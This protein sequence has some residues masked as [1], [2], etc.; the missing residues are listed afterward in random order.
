MPDQGYFSDP[1]IHNDIV[2][3]VCEDDL[4]T[5]PAGGGL[6]RRLTASPAQEA[7]PALSPDG[8]WLAFTSRDEGAPEIYAM[9][10]EGGPARRL[11]YLGAD[12][13]VVGWH[14][15]GD[16]IIFA[17]NTAQPIERIYALH[18]VKPSGGLPVLLP[19]GPAVSIS[20]GSV[21][22]NFGA[23]SGMAAAGVSSSGSFSERDSMPA[24]VSVSARGCVIG[25]H[26][27]DLAR[28]KRYRGGLAGALWIDPAGT[29]DW[30][31]LIELSGN[32]AAP[33]W[34]GER[35]YFLSDHEGV[36]NLY[37]C[38][39]D[40]GDLRR[41]TRHN[42]FYVR[43]PSTDGR[44]IVYQAGAD[45]YL[46][47]PVADTS[48]VIPIALHSPRAQRARR[49]VDAAHYLQGYAL[50]PAG[51]SL[52]LVARGKPFTM[53]N[54]EG[55]VVQH[56]LAQG[57]R[58]RLAAWLPDG[59]RLA[60]I[61]DAAGEETVE[62]HHADGSAEPDR[63]IGLD[64][65]RPEEVAVS[66]VADQLALSNQRYELILVDLAERS[67]RVLDRSRFDPLEGLA[68]SPDGKWLA[69]GL[70]VGQ[71][72]SII[73]LCRVETGQ[74]WDVTRPV[75]RDVSPAFDP[76]GDYLY[77]LSFRDF[78]PV[79]DNLHFDL[80]FPRG[81][82]P[83]LVTLRADLRS[84]FV[85]VPRPFKKPEVEREDDESDAAS[86]AGGP[87]TVPEDESETEPEVPP[88]TIDLDGLP[89][90]V[91]AFPVPAGRYGQVWGLPGKVLFSRFPIESAF[92]ESGVDAGEP[93]AR[94]KLAV[95]SFEDRE[96][97]E[98]V[99]GITD[100]EV[101]LDGS[102]LLY[103]AGDRLRVIEAGKKPPED[104]DDGDRPG[105]KS[106]WLDLGRVRVGVEPPGEWAQMYREA[107]RLQRDQFWTADMSGVDWQAIYERYRPLLDRVA[108][109]SE[110][111]DLLW[112]MQGELG[113]SHAYEFGGDYRPGPEY[114]QGFLGVDIAYDPADDGYRLA[115]IVAGDVW[116]DRAS[117]PL[118]RPG[119][120]AQP[121]D[122]ILA[123]NGQAV[124]GGV[125]PQEL[126]VNQAHNE[127]LLTLD[128]AAGRRSLA[129]P[130][131]RSEVPARYR[132]WVESNRRQVH[133]ATGGRVGYVHIP[134]MGE[135]GYAEFHRGYLLEVE[136]EGLIVD[137]RYNAGG[138][139]SQLILEKLARRRLGFDIRRWGEPIPY[140][141]ESV[142]GPLVALANE[143]SGSDGDMFAHA[144]KLMS[145]GPL[146]GKRTWGG[147]VG[148]EFRDTLVDNGI[149]TQ[150]EYAT[151]F[152]D[153]AYGLEN[154][155]TD[156]DIGVE[157]R[158]Q[159][160]VAGRDPQLERA[161]G[162][163]VRLLA[164]HPP[165]VP[166][167]LRMLP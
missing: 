61:S 23:E 139:V 2:V 112:E 46:Y 158:P 109:R 18:A 110:F 10:A 36:A 40:G 14:P 123:I 138:Y 163:A 113:T 62:I 1:T 63:L 65:G 115:R 132:D 121:G 111:S 156:P 166:G 87:S 80:N 45:L 24:L 88:I 72:T 125:A 146:I 100:F 83:Y 33:L 41:H 13:W 71:Q 92:D 39:I 17:S 154:Y 94:G 131:L 101:S 57:A 144:F 129:V 73:K 77:F 104:D 122:R 66:P 107:W 90:R 35:I 56:G 30:R 4:W 127:V 89:D 137:A 22:A 147:V 91:V 26:A 32:E 42:D 15:D 21:A 153:V 38:R 161:I 50:H 27:I 159:D 55:A 105:R 130:T 8:A 117:S 141:V 70:P 155:G 44:R 76:E 134:D 9:P 59:E 12:S 25:R 124:G 5:V 108:T 7:H 75:L 67:A 29:G 164:E 52:A 74:I 142:A 3:F 151:W 20:Y 162:E 160:Y 68:W 37:S 49:F 48:Q 86:T 47:D 118:A 95:Y 60:V 31:R 145:L 58:Y 96:Q 51:H 93:P 167:L 19:T 135:R 28:W 99:E 149:T 34:V 97:E 133:A 136:R 81:M 84:P 114:T 53:G 152:H 54:W 120:P 43:H 128:G 103:R 82:R 78:D 102:T 148:I 79:Y 85:P 150:P 143:L 119:V 165:L 16:T 116:D 126:L 69:Y 157:V 11:T 140:P 6:A 64:L 106:G 98:L